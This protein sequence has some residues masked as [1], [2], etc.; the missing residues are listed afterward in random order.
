MLQ[1]DK[2]DELIVERLR[3]NGELRL[4]ALVSFGVSAEAHRLAEITGR[5]DFRIVDG[6]LQALRKKGVIAFGPN[7]WRAVE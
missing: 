6:R 5:E 1:Y 4:F 7:G 3:T 2:L